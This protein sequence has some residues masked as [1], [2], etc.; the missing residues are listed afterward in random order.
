MNRKGVYFSFDAIIASIIFMLTVISLL[1]YWYSVREMVM[2]EDSLLSEEAQRIS[3][4]V[5]LPTADNEFGFALSYNTKTLNYTKIHQYADYISNNNIDLKGE[6]YTP[7]ETVI[8]FQFYEVQFGQLF[9]KSE[10]TIGNSI[11]DPKSVSKTV[12]IASVDN[13]QIAKISVLVYKS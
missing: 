9:L 11:S 10:L 1:S 13:K 4:L 2:S 12:R 6:L 7:Y 3:N 5:F 8:V